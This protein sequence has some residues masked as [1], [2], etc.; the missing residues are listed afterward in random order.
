MRNPNILPYPIGL[1]LSARRCNP[2]AERTEYAQ[3]KASRGIRSQRIRG[4][5]TIVRLDS[6]RQGLPVSAQDMQRWHGP[7]FAGARFER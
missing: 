2:D 5:L 7:I 3:R 1:L 4:Y 6:N